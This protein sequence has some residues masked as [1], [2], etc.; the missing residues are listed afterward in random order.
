MK[1]PE[2]TDHDRKVFQEELKPFLPKRIFDAHVHIVDRRTFLPD[3]VSEPKSCYNKFGG[4]H[5]LE[6]CRRIYEEMLPGI[7]VSFNCFGSPTDDVDREKAASIG[8]DNRRIFGMRLLSPD[9]PAELV[10]RSV[11]ENRLVGFKP[12]PDLAA[13]ACGKA[14]PDV[15]VKDMFSAEQLALID[16][17]KLI[18]TVHIPR[19]GRL[20]DPLNRKQ[21]VELCEKCPGGTFIFAHIGRAYF[22]KNVVGMLDS[23]AKCPNAW[24]DTAMVNHAGVM[25]YAFDHFP[26]E[27]MVFGSDAP[28]AFL[29]GKSVEINDSYAYLMGEDYRIGTAIFDSEG[30]VDFAP[31]Y[32]EQLR[33]VLECGLSRGSLEKF[34]FKNAF[35]LFTKTAERLYR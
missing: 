29:H 2:V 23:L 27:R 11:A 22:M 28:I 3:H 19:R 6:T 25:R 4:E 15:E 17:K 5:T 20:A 10:E 31:F 30:A 24:M 12:Y 16:R 1:Y 21:M 33:A 34:L 35:G 7:E 26:L 32:Y 18:C 9:D 13:A 8:N 14:V